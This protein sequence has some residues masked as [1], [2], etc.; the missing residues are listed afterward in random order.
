MVWDVLG[1]LLSR[2][3]KMCN[4]A[5]SRL[6]V[7]D[8]DLCTSTC[9]S[10]FVHLVSLSKMHFLRSEPQ[11]TSGESYLLKSLSAPFVVSTD[12]GPCTVIINT[13]IIFMASL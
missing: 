3:K 11:D 2:E 4:P 5:A 9:M 7:G 12:G 1:C 10:G 6:P 13:F 8:L